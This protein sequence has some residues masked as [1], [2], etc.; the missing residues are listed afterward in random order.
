MSV[1]SSRGQVGSAAVA[2]ATA[3]VPRTD[4]AMTTR[5]SNRAARRMIVLQGWGGD[6]GARPILGR[7]PAA[8]TPGHRARRHDVDARRALR[9]QRRASRRCGTL[10]RSTMKRV[11]FLFTLLLPVLGAAGPARAET[12]IGAVFGYPGNAGLSARFS[13]KAI[14]LAWSSDIL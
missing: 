3:T 5:D 12:A 8:V 13:D 9:Y 4:R 10:R 6:S 7:G 11:I 1:L 14:A 2:T